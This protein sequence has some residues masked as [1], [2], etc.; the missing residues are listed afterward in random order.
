MTSGRPGAAHI[1]LPYDVQREPV[2]DGE[3]W[4]DARLGRFPS[5][6][7]GPDPAA[8][9]AA[10]A[11]LLAAENPLFICG[12]GVVIAGAEAELQALA[13]WLGA[14]VAST[15][16]GH[17]SIA[18]HHPLAIGVVG[19]NGGTR[20]TRAIVQMADLVVFIGCRAGSVTTERWRFPAPGKVKIIHI[21]ADPAVIGASYPTDV[22]MISDARLALAELRRSLSQE[23]RPVTVRNL[24]ANRVAQAKA[25]KFAA[26]AALACSDERP[27]KP[28]RVVADLQAV[29]PED[30]IVVA[31]PGTPCP[32]FSAY[33]ELA[34]PGRYFWSNRA[35]GALGYS[36]AAAVG[37]AYGWPGAKVVSVM[38]D[39]SFAFTA[40]EMETMVRLKLPITMVVISNAAFGWIKAGQQ[41]G[42]EQRYFSVD[43]TRTEHA[44]VAAAFGVKSW[45]VEDPADLRA[46]LKRAVEAGEP[47]L[48]DIVCQPL[49]EAMAPVSEWVA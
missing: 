7:L 49:H 41:S 33:Y 25:E 4:G 16:S 46:T 44:A 28:E 13:E 6:R 10:V 18:D 26:F 1:G 2:D 30:A 20:P 12:G 43:F 5:R 39:G 27:I 3:I 21:D 9:E 35:H 37:A 45:K 31:D 8:I 34:R 32:Y 36:M 47:T 17:G 40:G 48:V 22:A 19:N 29:L 11:L 23:P 24:D 42:F 14:P 38:G 15:V